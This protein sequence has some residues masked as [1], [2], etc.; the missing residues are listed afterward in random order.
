MESIETSIKYL[1][2][3]GLA[4]SKLSTHRYSL[5]RQGEDALALLNEEGEYWVERWDYAPGPGPDDF[6][7]CAPSLDDALLVCWAYFFGAPIVLNGWVLHLH[8]YPFWPL[9][10]L[11]YR[12][13]QAVQ[14]S[15]FDFERVSEDRRSR[16]RTDQLGHM[17]GFALAETT[18]FLLAATRSDS[19]DLLYLRRDLEE[20]YIVVP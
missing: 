7:W 16:R 9:A 19:P 17:S 13:A 4:V 1:A 20:A 5:S 11:Q 2:E 12:V 14:L 18:Q 3:R 8:R 6:R 15:T 10:K